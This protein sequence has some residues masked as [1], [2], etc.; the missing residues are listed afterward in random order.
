MPPKYL[1]KGFLR[2]GGARFTIR[3]IIKKRLCRPAHH[4]RSN[5]SSHTL[6]M[7]VKICICGLID[8][9][10]VSDSGGNGNAT[11]NVPR[12]IRD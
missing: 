1:F 8:M 7:P 5:S 3:G 9:R 12:A 4:L 11:G 2:E 6:K 10:I